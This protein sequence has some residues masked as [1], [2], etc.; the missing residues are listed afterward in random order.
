MTTTSPPTATAV[1]LLGGNTADVR[2]L[3]VLPAN[4]LV[5]AADSGAETARHLGLDVHAVVGDM[6]SIAPTA[7]AALAALGTEIVRHPVDKNESDAELALRYAIQRGA[8]RIVLVSGGG[9]RLDHQLALF[10]VMFLDDLRGAHVEARLGGSRAYA[11]RDGGATTLT[12]NPGDVIGLLPFGGDAHGITTR[13]LR[14][15]LSNESLYVAASRGIS[16]RAISDEV[17]I[18][19]ASGR[20]IVTVDYPDEKEVQS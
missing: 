12:C 11:V 17:T 20:L 6:D 3:G 15:S 8:R 18:E 2:S 10:S 7:L 19:V 14:W 4:T 1:V 5:V 13:N 16:N 9:G